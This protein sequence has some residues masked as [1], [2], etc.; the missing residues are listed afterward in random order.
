[1]T[2]AQVLDIHED[3]IPRG[4]LRGWKVICGNWEHAGRPTDPEALQE[5]LDRQ[6]HILTENCLMR[7]PS[8]ALLRLKELQR[9]K[10]RPREG[11]GE[12]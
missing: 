7:W 1:M 3:R 9:G 11:V 2:L 6:L 12:P 8:V 4:D 10:F 5:F